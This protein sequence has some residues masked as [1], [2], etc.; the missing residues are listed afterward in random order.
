MA[1]KEL[2]FEELA[3]GYEPK[4]LKVLKKLNLRQEPSL[5]A[6]VIRI[7]PKGEEVVVLYD[8]GEWATTKE[9]FCMVKFLG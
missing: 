2:N 1:E 8:D 6:E 5:Q 3:Y 4:T 9:G 7:M